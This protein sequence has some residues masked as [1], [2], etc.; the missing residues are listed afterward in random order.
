MIQASAPQVVMISG[1]QHLIVRQQFLCNGTVADVHLIWHD[2]NK[3][4]TGLVIW[5]RHVTEL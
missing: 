4:V 2:H 1:D 5:G 3:T